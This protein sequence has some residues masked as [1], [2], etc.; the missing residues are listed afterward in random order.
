MSEATLPSSRRSWRTGAIIGSIVVVL[1]GL[2]LL[3]R[4][5]LALGPYQVARAYCQDHLAQ[6]SDHIY[7]SLFAP[8]LR[9]RATQSQYEAAEQ[10]ATAQAGT[11]SSCDVALW[12]IEGGTS[13]ATAFITEK[14]SGG[15]VITTTLQLSG[16]DWH[17]NQF[18]DAAMEPYIVIDHF[19][20]DLSTQAY[21]DAYQFFASSIRQQLTSETFGR[22]AKLADEQNGT[23]MH[24]SVSHITLAN[25]RSSA[26]V[27]ITTQRSQSGSSAIPVMTHLQQTQQ[28]WFID[29]VPGL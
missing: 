11:V 20:Q 13:S 16:S 25:D 28:G 12:N 26:E 8:V 23:I 15:T 14:R 17:I 1:A 24:C 9:A 29:V 5:G 4:I 22:L 3:F 21:P 7:T 10:L 18:P 27:T 19:C 6:H 2:V